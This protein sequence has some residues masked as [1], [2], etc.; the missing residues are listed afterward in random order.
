MAILARVVRGVKARERRVIP[1]HV[2]P[3]D[4]GAKVEH[5]EV[6]EGRVVDGETGHEGA[7]DGD[8]RDSTCDGL[9]GPGVGLACC[10]VCGASISPMGRGWT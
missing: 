3:R 8:G 6:R 1:G 10:V 5:L 9:V 2:E 4:L 7:I